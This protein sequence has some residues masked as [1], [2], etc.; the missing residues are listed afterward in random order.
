MFTIQIPTLNLKHSSPYVLTCFKHLD[1]LL[2]QVKNMSSVTIWHKR[3]HCFFY[4]FFVKAYSA[5]N[6]CHSNM[7]EHVTS[8]FRQLKYY[9]IKYT[10]LSIYK[11]A[12]Q[13]THIK[14]CSGDLNNKHLNNELLFVIIR[15]SV[16]QMVVR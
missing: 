1:L 8:H 15:M 6:C 7:N 14:L 3:F 9:N 2:S 13:C 5:Y 11:A 4:F 10:Q 16:I 12:K